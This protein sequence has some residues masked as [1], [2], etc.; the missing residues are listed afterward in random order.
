[1]RPLRLALA[2]A[3]ASTAP[4]AGCLEDESEPADAAAPDTAPP[5]DDGGP[6]PDAGPGDADQGPIEGALDCEAIC[7]AFE[8]RCDQAFTIIG[9]CG[10]CADIAEALAEAPSDIL[11]R[12]AAACGVA[13][14]TGDCRAYAV[15]LT[16]DDGHNARTE[17]G[18]TVEAR[19]ALTLMVADA[20]AVVG[21]KS[22]GGPGDLEV[23]FEAD[24]TFYGVE[25]DDLAAAADAAPLDAA[26]HPVTVLTAAGA[27]EYATGTTTLATWAL[28]GPFEL[29]AEVEDETGAALTLRVTGTL[30]R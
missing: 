13:H 21:A 11:E 26:D 25:F 10:D 2:A 23:W 15:C 18:V 30:A 29:T 3:L 16:D 12:A 14:E 6:E 20:W 22:D 4:L 5:E 24:G 7:Q 8:Q 27:V 1:M 28:D 17:G 19:G 9:D